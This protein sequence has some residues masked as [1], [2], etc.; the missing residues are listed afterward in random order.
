MKRKKIGIIGGGASGL[1]AAVA[2]AENLSGYQNEDIIIFEKKDRIGKKILATGNGK[3]NVT[4][5][6]FSIKEPD[7]FYRGGKPEQLSEIFSCFSEKDT[8]RKFEQMGVL[9]MSRNGYIYPLSQQASTILDA[10]RFE[11]DRLGVC[12]ETEC[13]I[14]EIRRKKSGFELYSDKGSWFVDRLIL[15][16]GTPAGEKQGEG[17][18]GYRMAASLGH[19]VQGPWPALVQLR[20][21][22]NFWKGL[23]GV[24][25]DADICL[26]VDG[27]KGEKRWCERGELQ[28]TDYGISGIP[29]FQLSRYA[30]MGLD[31]G[32]KVRAVIDFMPEIKDWKGFVQNRIKNFYGRSM[33]VL[34]GGLVNKKIIQVLLKLCGLKLQD[35]L[36][37]SSEK[38]AGDVFSLL[39]SFEVIIC[40]ANPFSS[41]QVCAGGIPLREVSVRMES[42][43]MEG[44]YLTGELL[45]VDGR[46]G[47][48]NLQWAWSSG[49]LA[50]RDAARSLN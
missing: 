16:C 25:T 30:S 32:A 19:T 2:A 20:C 43:R 18:D 47:G 48:Y 27:K 1:M 46:C 4:N 50:G 15:A 7:L 29:V 39:K 8:I 22:G 34:F 49:Y 3:C 41:A 36:D 42:L 33:E 23:A 13:A 9:L 10:F 35:L 31:R 26:I 37:H 21:E 44:M 45:D 6:E 40:A 38:R 17:L 24:R 12:V 11:L 5:L 28:L 14:S